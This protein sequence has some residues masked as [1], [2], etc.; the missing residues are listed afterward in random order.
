MTG[1]TLQTS[2]SVRSRSGRTNTSNWIHDP[3]GLRPRRGYSGPPTTGGVGTI[4]HPK[5]AQEARRQLGA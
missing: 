1:S 2:S 4:D 5:T 3:R